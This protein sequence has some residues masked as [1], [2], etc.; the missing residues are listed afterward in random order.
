M[1]PLRKDPSP[2]FR[3]AVAEE[4]QHR[5][6]HLRAF[7]FPE[8][9]RDPGRAVVCIHGM[10]ADG[11]SF[12]RQRPLSRER[13]M[14]LLNLPESTPPGVDPLQFQADAVEEFLD[15]AKLDRPALIGSSFGGAVAAEVALRRSSRLSALVLVAAVV[16][17]RQIP[18][19][20]PRFVDLL[21]APEPF[22]RL[23]APL[24]AQI[25][26][27][28]KL[29]RDAR[30]EIVRE[31]RNV[32]GGEFNRR[33]LSLME[34]DLLP[35]LGEIR[36][37]TL[38]VHGTWDWMVPWRRGRLVSEALPGCGFVLV[39]GAGHLP[40][41][42]H[43]VPFN[44]AVQAFLNQ[45]AG[46]SARESSKGTLRGPTDVI[47]GTPPRRPPCS[48]LPHCF[49]PREPARRCRFPAARS[50][51]RSSV[52]RLPVSRWPPRRR[53]KSY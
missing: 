1:A 48:P 12:A 28:P 47:I 49:S 13:F 10:G 42:S 9:L 35:R 36:L 41:L 44:Q 20:T 18:L 51:P 25:M 5:S 21:Q 27:G 22:A 50:S 39:R 24:A 30:D 26:G 19:A 46:R 17:R 43:P 8:G 45:S 2:S 3:D 52:S 23:L 40:Y 29:D 31:S 34:L 15:A 32:T 14:L 53:C 38:A 4:L 6:K 7:Q 37:P 11:R 33:L 16:S